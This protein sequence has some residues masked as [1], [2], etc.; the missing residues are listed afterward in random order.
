M[1]ERIVIRGYRLFRD[2]EIEPR[3]GMNIIVGDNEAGKSSLIEALNL[4]LTGKVNGR[5]AADELNPYWFNLGGA[6]AF[7]TAYDVDPKTKKPEI[8]LEAYL[9]NDDDQLQTLRGVYNTRQEDA[10]GLSLTISPSPDYEEE[11]EAYL[12]AENRP[13]VIPVEYYDVVWQDF[14]GEYLAKRPKALGVS[15]ID[16]RTIR[17][18]SGVDYHTRELLSAYVEPKE[19][20]AI[21][22]EHRKARHVITQQALGSV[23]ERIAEQGAAVHDRAI[24]L[25]MDQSANASWEA[26]IVPQVADIP[27]A[28]AGQGQQAAIKVALAMHRTADQTAYV[29]IEEPE[30][31]LSHTTLTKLL[32][33]IEAM[34]GERQL[35]VS[36]HSSYV[37]NRLGLDKLIL[38][39]QG[40]RAGFEDLPEDTVRYFKRLSGFDT[41]RLVLADS[42]ALVEGP[43]DEMLFERAYADRH[44]G[45][46]PISRGIDVV[47]MHGVALARSLQLCAA[48][49][50]R[51][52][53]IRDNDG[54]EP[55]HWTDQL[56]DHLIAGKRE[57][58]IGSPANGRTLEPQ[59]VSVND[60]TALGTVL[61]LDAR[62]DVAAWMGSH[63][64]DAAL[65]I[66][67]ADTAI[68]YPKYLLDAIE[69]FG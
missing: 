17:S 18:T 65:R 45:V 20:A 34:A 14:S 33:R 38:L 5:R 28:M 58:F 56:A 59:L 23:N 1:I 61:G 15:F 31:H 68:T 60:A 63:K 49:D 48:L 64:T 8:L 22:V 3:P 9:S 36:T 29:L 62:E 37:L 4:V 7:F 27:F 16:A 40:R 10:P 54:R 50:R 52:A 51:V 35:F 12:N 24:G 55:E 26:S 44:D 13:N 39:H 67:E 41:L 11:F 57:I 42:V 53:A 69:F 2:L 32:G 43:S 21:S 6:Q 66:A 30:N 47:S 25:Q 19:R 46:T